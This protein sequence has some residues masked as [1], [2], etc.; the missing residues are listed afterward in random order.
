[1]SKPLSKKPLVSVIIPV[2]RAEKHI[3]KCILSVLEQTF[4][5]IELI[6]IDDRGE[7]N[8]FK[9]A[10]KLQKKDN[11]IY[12]LRN[13]KNEGVDYSRFKGIAQAKADYLMFVDADDW[14]PKDAIRILY[15][16]IKAENADV[17]TGTY[18]KVLDKFGLIRSRR[19]NN[20]TIKN[21]LHTLTQPELFDEY[22]ISYFG[23]NI[24]LVSLW[25]KLYRKDKILEANL[26]PTGF[27]NGEDLLFNMQLHPYLEKMAF[28]TQ[29]VYF[30]RY[31]GVTSQLNPTLLEDV[32]KQYRLRKEVLL[33]TNYPKALPYLKIELANVFYSFFMSQF[34]IAKK[35]KEVVLQN[36]K[37]EIKNPI[38]KELEGV[39]HP[40][41]EKIFHQEIDLIFVEIYNLYRKRRYNR[42][43]KKGINRF[44]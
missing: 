38:Y 42:R 14:I 23:R 22:F 25:G 37:K 18:T 10:E 27:K 6:I 43:L 30:H 1:M 39:D 15:H 31:G 34:L 36:L 44:L 17:V 7:D 32:K 2:Y 21:I 5:E 3:E 8:S 4:K 41:T 19:N 28:V 16:K 26:K 20:Y 40:R 24:L 13:E 29:N 35:S 33:K 11:R 9:I 12:L